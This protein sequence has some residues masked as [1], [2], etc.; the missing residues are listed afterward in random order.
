MIELAFLQQCAPNVDP[1]ISN[2]IVKTESSFNPFAI[3]VN[4]GKRISQPKNYAQAVATAKYLLENGANIDLGLSQINSSNLRGLGLSVEQIFNPC[5]NLRAM[6]TI[7]LQC[8]NSAG[9]SGSGTRIQRAFSCYNTGNHRKGF[10]NGYV[11][12][13][14]KNFN[15]FGGRFAPSPRPQNPSVYQ[16]R[17]API[18][19]PAAIAVS[20]PKM[21]QIQPNQGQQQQTAYVP[22]VK[23]VLDV[24]QDIASVETNDQP[25]EV[26]AFHNWDI[27]GDF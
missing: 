16:A 25:I 5:V 12:K 27:F 18:A 4:R 19:P 9:N 21:P 23:N 8:Y 3:G 14:T 1:I 15:F 2:A 6:Q 13:A 7:Y 26:R 20:V 22:I 10:N 17:N 11:T 24:Q